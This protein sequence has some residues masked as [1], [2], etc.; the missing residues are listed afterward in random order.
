[1]GGGFVFQGD[2]ADLKRERVKR[3]TQYDSGGISFQDDGKKSYKENN[4]S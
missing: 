3:K 4:M 2:K 1:V